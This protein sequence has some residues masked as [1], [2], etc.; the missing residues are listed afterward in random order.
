MARGLYIDPR[1]GR[2]TL[3][4]WSETW[5]TRPGKRAASTARD[6]QG[7]AAFLPL[8]GSVYLSGLTLDSSKAPSM[9]GP[10]SPFRPP[11][12]VSSRRSGLPSTLRWTLSWFRGRRL[13]RS[14]CHGLCLRS[15][16]D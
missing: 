11:W 6:R 15:N 13:G 14:H 10:R 9:L 2:V 3:I 1:A 7:I 4:E 16:P 8:I 12:H 5:L